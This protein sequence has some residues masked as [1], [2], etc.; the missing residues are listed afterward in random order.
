MHERDLVAGGFEESQF[1][2][3][4]KQKLFICCRY[5]C[6]SQYHHICHRFN[7]VWL[8]ERQEDFGDEVE[9]MVGLLQGRQLVS[10][11]VVVMVVEGR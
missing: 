6:C 2:D 1:K 5:T 10:C 8:T 3:K 9:M 7:G 11:E 4:T